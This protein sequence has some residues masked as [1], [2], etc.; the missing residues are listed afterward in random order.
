MSEIFSGHPIVVRHHGG[1]RFVASA[2]S[3][4]IATDQPLRSGGTDCGATPL[5]LLGA[6]LGSCIALYVQQFCEA[7]DLPAVGMRVEVSQKNES[8]PNRV[9]SFSVRVVLPDEMPTEYVTILER[10]VRSCPVHNT[11]SMGSA[12]HVELAVPAAV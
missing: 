12:I 9:G 8:G 3:H 10:V 7:R 5:E 11:L 6:A 1:L 2:R 4:E